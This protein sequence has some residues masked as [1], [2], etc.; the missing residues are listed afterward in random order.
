MYDTPAVIP[1]LDTRPVEA[2]VHAVEQQATAGAKHSRCFTEHGRQVIEI[3]MNPD[4][5]DVV[6]P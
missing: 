4:A 5:R 1:A 3:A 2:R 6:V